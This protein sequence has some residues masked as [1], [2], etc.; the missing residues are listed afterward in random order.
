MLY[1]KRCKNC[2]N[3][4]S[5]TLDIDNPFLYYALCG[6][7]NGDI[8]ISQKHPTVIED[9]VWSGAS[10][11]I[12]SGV[13]VHKGGIGAV[14]TKDVLLYAIVGACHCITV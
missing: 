14:V 5:T 3:E 10:A 7:I 2:I 8:A 9:D 13:V 6:F 12:L 1:C 11:I 4:L